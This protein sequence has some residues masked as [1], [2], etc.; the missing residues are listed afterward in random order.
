[1]KI[2]ISLYLIFCLIHIYLQQ[3]AAYLV[4]NI[5][6]YEDINSKA[7]KFVF[8]QSQITITATKLFITT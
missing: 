6:G 3:N 2:N 8:L 4:N 1:M 7:T 5:S